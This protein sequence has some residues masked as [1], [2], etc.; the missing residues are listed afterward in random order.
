MPFL[1][2]LEFPAGKESFFSSRMVTV[3]DLASGIGGSLLLHILVLLTALSF[4]FLQIHR[5]V[6]NPF[7]TVNLMGFGESEGCSTGAGNGGAGEGGK[8]RAAEVTV[9]SR[10]PVTSVETVSDLASKQLQIDNS[11]S[12]TKQPEKSFLTAESKVIRPTG[13]IMHREKTSRK[14]RT[15]S[16]AESKI[17]PVPK[18]SSADSVKT[19]SFASLQEPVSQESETGA[20]DMKENAYGEGLAGDNAGAGTATGGSA[21]SA[22]SSYGAGSGAG[23]FNIE[24]VDQAPRVLRKVEPVYPFRARNQ[25]I[26]GKLLLKFLVEPDGSVSKPCVLEAHPEGFF[27]Q[28]A[29][30]AV[31]Q[32]RFKP[33]FYRGRAV[34]TWIVL[35]I[36]FKLIR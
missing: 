29:L 28:N 6:Q 33:G 24:Q 11:P 16:P 26:D 20:G 25:A 1:E 31:T 19:S 22:G 10:T 7:I 36:R 3:K 32:W 35:P 2:N 9:K 30:A 15:P 8:N 27:E 4:P 13:S 5:E 12:T 21:G 18:S 17:E 14:L 34:A 23:E